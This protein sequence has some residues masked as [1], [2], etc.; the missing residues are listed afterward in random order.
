MN[1]T[2]TWMRPYQILPGRAHPEMKMHA[3]EREG[4]KR[5]RKGGRERGKFWRE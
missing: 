5:E 2:E 3:G 4:G 1:I